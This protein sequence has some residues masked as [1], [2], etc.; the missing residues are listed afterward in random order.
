MELPE[1]MVDRCTCAPIRDTGKHPIV[2]LR[3]HGQISNT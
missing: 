3:N 1:K 2:V